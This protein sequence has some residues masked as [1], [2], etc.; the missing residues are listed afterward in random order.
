[1]PPRPRVV[2]SP[3][4]EALLALI[5]QARQ[6]P[7]AVAASM[8]M[9]PEKILKDLPE[10]EKILKEGLPPVTFNGNLYEAAR[11]HTQDMFANGY[12]SH[13]LPRRPGL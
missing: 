10:L 8:G 9:D 2:P 13:D 5:N 11:A 1:M 12:Y 6:N 3:H 7:L 4:E